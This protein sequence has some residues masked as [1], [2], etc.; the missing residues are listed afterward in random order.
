MDKQLGLIEQLRR[1]ALPK[2][3]YAPEAWRNYDPNAVMPPVPITPAEAP[4]RTRRETQ[5]EEELD[6]ANR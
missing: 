6:K 3:W 1:R 4:R 5:I 2:G